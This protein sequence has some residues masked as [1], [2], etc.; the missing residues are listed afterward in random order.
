VQKRRRERGLEIGR[1]SEEEGGDLNSSLFAFNPF[2]ISFYS[3][4]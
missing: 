2:T 3:A 1:K 4:V